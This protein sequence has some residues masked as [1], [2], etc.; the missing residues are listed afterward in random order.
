MDKVRDIVNLAVEVLSEYGTEDGGTRIERMA[1]WIILN[2]VDTDAG[3]CDERIYTS[4]ECD[5]MRRLATAL[6]VCVERSES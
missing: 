5:G 2:L 3:E 6:F 4:K 1:T